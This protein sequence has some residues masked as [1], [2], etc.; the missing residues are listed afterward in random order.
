MFGPFIL[1]SP[2]PS[3]IFHFAGIEGHKT[4]INKPIVHS[5]PFMEEPMRYS[6][7]I[8]RKSHTVRAHTA[9]ITFPSCM[10]TFNTKIIP[11]F[12]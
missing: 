12:Y 6:R 2:A 5:Q 10:S 4:K 8:Q 3:P 11:R 9:F 1:I 7:Q